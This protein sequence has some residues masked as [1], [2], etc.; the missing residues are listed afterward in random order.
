MGRHTVSRAI[1]AIGDDQ[2][3]WSALYRLFERNRI[4]LSKIQECLLGHLLNTGNQEEPLLFFADDTL[5]RKQGRKVSGTGWKLDPLGPKFTNNF[6]WAQR[7]LQISL[8]YREKDGHCR[9]IPILF[10]HCPVPHKPEKRASA[11]V[12]QGY[13]VQQKSHRITVKAAACMN[14]LQSRVPSNKR[15]IFIGDGGYSNRT[16]VDAVKQINCY[17]GRIRKNSNLFTVPETQNAGKGRKRYYGAAL[18]SPEEIRQED[19]GWKEVKAYTGNGSHTFKV[20]SITP[21]RSR[22]AGDKD[23]KILIIQPLRYRLSQKT[24]L[25]Y[26]DPAYLI[27]T[28]PTVDDA[29]ILQY[30]LWRWEIEVNFKDE[31][32]IFGIHEPQVRAANAVNS[33]PEFIAMIYALFLLA[34]KQTF[35]DDNHFS[36]PKWRSPKTVWRPSTANYLSAFRTAVL[37]QATNK[38][39][40]TTTTR[41]NTKP[42]LFKTDW[43]TVIYNAVN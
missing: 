5:L 19:S 22:M 38:N 29:E 41:G 36:Y 4:D 10:R 3:D 14:E 37:A 27:C 18:P 7:Y 11:E 13:K 40:F 12:H 39:D 42:L 2:R 15:I 21:V 9:G 35:G 20:K 24:R 34:A 23:V 28:D 1:S 17:I 31:K 16:V 26:R 30:Y 32:S 25:L 8:G 6:I 43:E 33:L